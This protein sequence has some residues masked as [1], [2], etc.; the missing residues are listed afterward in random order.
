MSKFSPF[1]EKAGMQ[2]VAQQPSS[3]RISKVPEELSEMSLDLQLLTNKFHLYF[4]AN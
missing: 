3:E 1:A 4:I 2:K